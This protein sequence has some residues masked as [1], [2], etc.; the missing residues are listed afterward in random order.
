MLG[1]SGCLD[2]V[3]TMCFCLFL[4]CV[5][6]LSCVGR[7]CTKVP[8]QMRIKQLPTQRRC[9][10]DLDAY[11]VVYCP[12]TRKPEVFKQK[13]LP[14]GSVASVTAFL[15]VSQAIWKIGT[16]LLG[17]MWSSYFDDFYPVEAESCVAIQTWLYPP[18]LG[19]WDGN[20]H[21]TS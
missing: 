1:P 20:C 7:L 3:W 2:S 6:V 11:L 5:P 18:C 19:S 21:P 8:R 4:V 14:F 17:L 13:V 9:L 16:V 15:R 10:Y 12:E